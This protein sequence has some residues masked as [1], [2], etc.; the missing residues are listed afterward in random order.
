MRTT[1][2]RQAAERSGRRAEGFAALFL[3]LKGYRIL[4]RR[5]RVP[6]GEIDIVARRGG[7][8]AFVEVKRRAD[9]DEA[10]LAV[11]FAARRRIVRAADAFL[12]RR[13]GLAGL[14]LRYDIVIVRRR[15]LPIHLA[16][17]FRADD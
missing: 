6:A 5:F 14:T 3:M 7:V 16:N 13:P 2:E 17:A 10:R 15:R 9:A 11:T 8:L 12:A 1:P 4:A